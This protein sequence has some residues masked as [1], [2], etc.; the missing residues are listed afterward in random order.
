[1]DESDESHVLARVA[2]GLRLDEKHPPGR[3]PSGR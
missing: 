3:Y 2:K 1:M